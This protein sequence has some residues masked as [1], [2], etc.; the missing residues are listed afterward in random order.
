VIIDAIGV[1]QSLKTTSQPLITQPSIPLKD[2][3]MSVMMGVRDEDTVSSLAGRLARLNQQLGDRDRAR[4]CEQTGGLE[5]E[6]IVGNLLAA[7]DP[8]RVE[9][10][11]RENAGLP[12]GTDPGEEQRTQAQEQLVEEAASI[13]NGDLI[14]LLEGI[15]RD[16]EQ[17][18]D[19]DNL[20]TLLRAEWAGGRQG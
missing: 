8:D 12:D 11:A 3:A 14:Q 15:R 6:Q 17:I 1:A 18:I 10:K 7:I 5:L 19:H 9:N 2:L 13:F 16:K 4:I 20:D